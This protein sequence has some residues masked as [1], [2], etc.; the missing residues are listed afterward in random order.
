VVMLGHAQGYQ[1]PAAQGG[2]RASATVCLLRLGGKS[3]ISMQQ[4]S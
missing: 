2:S 1:E 3:C 4:G